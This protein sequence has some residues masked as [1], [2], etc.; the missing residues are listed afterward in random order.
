MPSRQRK[1]N[2]NKKYSMPADN[3]QDSGAQWAL[4]PTPHYM[5]I[6]TYTGLM[7]YVW[8]EQMRNVQTQTRVHLT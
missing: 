4:N 5:G 1:Q 8:T 2:I 7:F 6:M 3:Q